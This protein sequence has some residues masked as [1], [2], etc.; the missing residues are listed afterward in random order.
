MFSCANNVTEC[1]VV[2]CVVLYV[3]VVG[4]VLPAPVLLVLEW[5]AAELTALHLRLP[6]VTVPENQS[7]GPILETIF[8]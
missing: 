4:E 5:Q 6:C 2:L 8:S 3:P 7:F 1:L